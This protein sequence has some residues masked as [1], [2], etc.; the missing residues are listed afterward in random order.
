MHQFVHKE[1][2]HVP[3]QTHVIVLLD[4][5]DLDVN[6]YNASV[7]IRH[8]LHQSV[9]I[10]ELV[11]L[12]ISVCVILDILA[13]CVNILFAIISH[14]QTLMFV[15]DMVLAYEP[16]LVYVNKEN[17]SEIIALFLFAL[18]FQQTIQ[19]SVRMD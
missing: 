6:M 2:V 15:M 5:Q 13:I 11:S 8:P 10:M 16:T 12:Q 4:L 9:P 14:P 19:E 17:I 7:L 18:E 3:L 1:M